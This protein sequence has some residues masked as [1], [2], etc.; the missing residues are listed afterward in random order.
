MSDAPP[1]AVEAAAKAVHDIVCLS[2]P[3]HCD[4]EPLEVHHDAAVAALAAAEKVWPHDP[5]AR[6]AASTITCS[7]ERAWSPV[8]R[9]RASP[10]GIGFTGDVNA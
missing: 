1:L 7:T 5:P 3:G 6:D 9:V 4:G 10:R 2:H 8:H